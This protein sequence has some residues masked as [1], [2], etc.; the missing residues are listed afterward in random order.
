MAAL[1]EVQSLNEIQYKSKIRIFFLILLI[2]C[3]FVVSFLSFFPISDKIKSV[4]KTTFKGRGCNPDFDRI[5][6]EWVMPKIVISDLVLPAAC[7]Q[8]A[9]APLKFSHVTLNWHLINFA[10][11]G[12][13][14]RLDTELEGQPLSI[15]FVQGL[16]Q[17]MIRLKDQSLNLGRLRSL[18][19]DNV[20]ISGDVTVDL[21]AMMSNRAIS[22]LSL[23]AQSKNLQVPSQ[24]LQGFTTPPLKLNEFYLEANSANHPRINI[25]KLIVGDT[26]SPVRA[27][28]KGTIDLQE[29]NVAFSPM[30]LTG[31]V[32]F[33]ENFRQS[34]PLIEMMFQSFTQKDGFY[35]I[36][37]GGTL[38]APKPSAP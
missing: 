6:M 8:R 11:F 12:L 7:L 16:N 37:L 35:Q 4:L 31:E 22:D 2:F 18:L 23:K 26:E 17:Q 1:S 20:K 19:G 27:N 9:G 33:S 14:F 13:P 25:D 24:N 5:S 28:F 15:Y 38:G 30:N 10:P 3:L 29:G 36:R 34:L 21:S 32:A